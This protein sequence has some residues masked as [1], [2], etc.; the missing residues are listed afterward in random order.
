[1]TAPR[2][3]RAYSLLS[4]LSIGATIVKGTLPAPQR[5]AL[6]MVIE[7]AGLLLDELKEIREQ[8]SKGPGNG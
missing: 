3:K 8:Q 6:E 7:L 4:Q 2:I 1:M 5:A